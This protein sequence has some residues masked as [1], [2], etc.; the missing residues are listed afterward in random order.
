M[1]DDKRVNI[2][3]EDDFGRVQT[4]IKTKLS[5]SMLMDKILELDEIDMNKQFRESGECENCFH[6]DTIIDWEQG[7]FYE[8]LM[9][10]NELKQCRWYE[11]DRE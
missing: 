6:L 2:V 7:V 8:C 10:E 1:I 4:I 9:G 11:D 3:L 5:P